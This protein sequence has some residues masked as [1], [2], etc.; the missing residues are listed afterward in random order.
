MVQNN[1]PPA[2]QFY[3][4]DW[5]A[6]AKVQTLTTAQEG[7]YIR[8]LCYC[9]R[10]GFLP[11]DSSAIAQL[12]KRDVTELDIEHVLKLFFVL[13]DGQ[14]HNPRLEKERIKQIEHAKERSKSGK[15]GAKK[16]WQKEHGLAIAEPLAEPMAKNSSSSSSLSSSSIDILSKDNISK[17][18]KKT[19]IIRSTDDI[20]NYQDITPNYFIPLNQWL[21]Y[22]VQIGNGYKSIDAIRKLIKQFPTTEKLQ[23]AVNIS[24]ANN[25]LGCFPPKGNG[26]QFKT[27]K[28]IDREQK[29]LRDK[30]FLENF[31]ETLLP[32]M[33]N[34]Q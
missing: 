12:C 6:D 11:V 32:Y 5:L 31:K 15:L 4:A 2:F 27:A 24:M 29:E 22:K 17:G 7:I 34:K 26:S 30:E 18:S 28:Q 25:W 8:L 3:P 33:E 20:P 21:A 16:R 9:W 14:Y 23:E 13:K 10:E 1:K 19:K